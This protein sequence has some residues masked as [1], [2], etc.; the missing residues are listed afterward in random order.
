MPSLFE[1]LNAELSGVMT[2][3]SR[4]VVQVRDESRGAGAG[5]IWHADGLIITN[6]HVA[7][8]G[9]LKVALYDGRVLDARLIA[10]D[11]ER[12]LAALVVDAHELPTIQIGSSRTL[13]AGQWV[14]SLGHPWGILNAASGGVVISTGKPAPELRAGHNDWVVCDLHLRP[15]NSGGP[16]FDVHGRLIGVNTM[17]TSPNVG[18]AVGVDA[19]KDFLKRTIGSASAAPPASGGSGVDAP[20]PSMFV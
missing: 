11:E 16:L 6:A 5:M 3:V 14:M 12:D 7:R 1:E 17:I 8:R 19:V 10:R 13:Q 20:Q 15:G 2:D 4:S 9:P 18:V